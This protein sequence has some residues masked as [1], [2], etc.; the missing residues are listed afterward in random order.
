MFSGIIQAQGR[1]SKVFK[2]IG[3]PLW[4]PGH[5]QDAPRWHQHGPRRMQ[6]GPKTAKDLQVFSYVEASGASERAKRTKRMGSYIFI[7]FLVSYKFL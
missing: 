5:A 4:T 6:D 3:E 7:I 2:E 1:I